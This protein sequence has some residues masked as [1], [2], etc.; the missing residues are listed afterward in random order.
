M[1]MESKAQNRLMHS[2]AENPEVAQRMGIPQSVGKAFVRDSRGQ[3]Q[4]R[5]PERVVHKAE[6]GPVSGTYPPKFS[7]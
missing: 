2:V 4:S 5:L 1:P 7:W 6:G 3:D